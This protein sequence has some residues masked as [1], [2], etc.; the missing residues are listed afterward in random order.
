MTDEGYYFTEK[1]GRRA[2]AASIRVTRI[3]LVP[4]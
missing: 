4:I 1:E 2:S 3:V